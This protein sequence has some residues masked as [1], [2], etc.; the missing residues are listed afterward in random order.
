MTTVSKPET[1]IPVSLVPVSTPSW[2][3]VDAVL[4]EEPDPT[5]ETAEEVTETVSLDETPRKRRRRQHKKKNKKKQDI[6]TAAPA[7]QSSYAEED[8]QATVEDYVE[9]NEEPATEVPLRQP[10][11]RIIFDEDGQA[12]EVLLRTG[13]QVNRRQQK[14]LATSNYKWSDA[15]EFASAATVLP[16][17]AGQKRSRPEHLGRTSA[18]EAAAPKNLEVRVHRFPNDYSTVVNYWYTTLEWLDKNAYEAQRSAQYVDPEEVA[19]ALDEF[20]T[21][22]EADLEL[23]RQATPLNAAD[24]DEDTSEPGAETGSLES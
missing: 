10:F 6:H 8:E 2:V 19:G 3:N 24:A 1:T 16:V 9:E 5:G 13:L 4:S 12:C 23:L 20:S 18:V 17:V 11:Q 7:S 22:L 15:A 14:R 21:A